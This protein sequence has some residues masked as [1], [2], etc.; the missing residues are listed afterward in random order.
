MYLILRVNVL[1]T[2]SVSSYILACTCANNQIC[3][4]MRAH[5]HAHI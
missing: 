3:T 5:V 1:R 2:P 4:R